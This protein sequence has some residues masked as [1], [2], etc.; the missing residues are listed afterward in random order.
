MKKVVV[1]AGLALCLGAPLLA[2]A[3][4]DAETLKIGV[5][6]PLTGGGAPWGIAGDQAARI[7]AAEINAKGGLEVGGKKYQIEVISYDDQFKT[8]D[9][10][11]A[12]N[13]LVN[14]DGVKYMIL[15]TSNGATALKDRIESDKVIV[16]TAGYGPKVVDDT[17]HFLYRWDSAPRDYMPG[18]ATWLRANVK[19]KT[20]ALVNPNIEG[21]VEQRV[22]ANDLYTKVG[23]DVVGSNLYEMSEKD[24]APLL[25][26]VIALH[27]DIIDVG[28]SAPATSG[29]IVRQ[30]RE[31]GYK[32]V[33]IKTAGP[34]PYD[35]VAG[36]GKEAA[37]GMINIVFSDPA[38]QEYQRLAGIYKKTVG[39]IPN[40]FF[41]VGYDSVMIMLH[42]IQ[43]AGTVD[44]TVKVR[45][46][47]AQV[48]PTKGMMGDEI[49]LG[50]KATY[51]SDQEFINTIYMA[52]IRDGVPVVVGKVR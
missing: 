4:A 19:G 47:I 41:V 32:G 10:V 24:F 1:A 45:D 26:K 16:L 30:A 52:E 28:S 5:V 22:L 50:G 31:L 9:A 37:Q 35:V 11:G 7:A 36:A 27:P 48:L 25:T 14:Q 8:A 18:M 3:A 46:A 49:L 29:L 44:D 23:F 6:A 33:I 42:A 21:A 34:G 40:D 2:G 12:Y 15:E 51:G 38:N 20:I 17:N 13:R 43:K 39:Q